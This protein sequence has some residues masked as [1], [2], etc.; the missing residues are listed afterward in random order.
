MVALE[1]F[2]GVRRAGWILVGDGEGVVGLDVV[3]AGAGDS[4]RRNGEVRGE[5]NESGDGLYVDGIAILR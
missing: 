5:P 2:E 3:E 4:G 1:N